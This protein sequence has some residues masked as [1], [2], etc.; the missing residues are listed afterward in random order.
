M[1]RCNRINLPLPRFSQGPDLGQQV[2]MFK[3]IGGMKG[4]GKQMVA[5]LVAPSLERIAM[6]LQEITIEFVGG[7]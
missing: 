5:Q 1:L 6:H 4:S 3:L 2:D 7:C